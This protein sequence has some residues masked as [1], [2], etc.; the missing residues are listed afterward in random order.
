MEFVPLRDTV[1]NYLAR[2]DPELKKVFCG[3]FPA[4]KLPP[5][6][7]WRVFSDAYIVG[8]RFG[9]EI[10]CVKCLTVMIYYSLA[11]KTPPY[12]LGLNNGKK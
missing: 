9:H 4:N 7:K 10:E 1:L 5:V 2:E 3:V 11:T 8:W 6:T 12:K